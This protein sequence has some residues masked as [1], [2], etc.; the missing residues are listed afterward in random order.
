MT[1]DKHN[2]EP[3]HHHQPQQV[4][5]CETEH[6]LF[7]ADQLLVGDLRRKARS[8]CN[9][10]N[11][12]PGTKHERRGY[13]AAQVKPLR[14]FRWWRPKSLKRAHEPQANQQDPHARYHYPGQDD[15]QR[16]EAVL[17]G[18]IVTV[19][20]SAPQILL[21]SPN[22]NDYPGLRPLCGFV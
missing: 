13:Q 19:Q 6:G 3:H 10:C 8:D 5:D 2:H 20:R 1:C 18:P 14:P 16:A 22:P 17:H 9:R 12:E 7:P 4:S 21:A 15:Q 11:E